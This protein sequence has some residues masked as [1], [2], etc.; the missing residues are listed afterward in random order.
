MININFYKGFSKIQL[1][2]DN[3]V[4]RQITKLIGWQNPNYIYTPAYKN[5][6]WMG[7][8]SF[9]SKGFIA[10]YGSIDFI[11]SYLN[12]INYP[13]E[14][15]EKL[16]NIVYD[17]SFL[18]D[19][20]LSI[21]GSPVEIRS[22]QK[23]AVEY[24]IINNRSVIVSATGSGKTIILYMLCQYYLRNN[25]KVLIIVPTIELCRQALSDFKS[26]GY[27]GEMNAVYSGQEKVSKCIT[28]TTYQSLVKN[29]NL[30]QEFDALIIDECHKA[31]ASS[32][33]KIL[34]SSLNIRFK[35]GMTGSLKDGSEEKAVATFFIGT[36]KVFTKSK[37]LMENK[38]LANLIVSA[39]RFRYSKETNDKILTSWYRDEVTF[40]NKDFLRNKKIIDIAV[41]FNKTG[42]I[43][44]NEIAHCDLL[45][46]LV[47]KYYPE[48]NVYQIRGNYNERNDVMYKTFNELKSMIEDEVNAILIV[49]L[50]VFST[51]ISLKN[52]HFGIMGISTKSYVTLIQ[53]IGRGLRLNANKQSFYFVDI[54]DDFR[55]T[56]DD[57]NYSIVHFQEREKYYKE[58]GFYVNKTT[59]Y[60]N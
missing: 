5:F 19:F 55:N 54:V 20:S 1:T 12:Q 17:Y 22:Y 25:L 18:K 3:D 44:V 31:K 21:N 15:D 51:G 57:S 4:L 24:A 34:N 2:G 60:L 53:S 8:T 28:V 47:R 37:D 6:G 7:W 13:Y 27:T 36:P 39:V 23:E 43:A 46:K 30:L 14:L 11:L 29:L 56:I 16:K 38:V 42:M 33:K 48:R 10:P 35:T 52:L 45:Y 50:K 9:I 49:G 41:G 58:Q 32:M 26:Y 59:L 40:L